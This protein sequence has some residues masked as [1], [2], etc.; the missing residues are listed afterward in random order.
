M[1]IA[2]AFLAA[3]QREN[4]SFS[5]SLNFHMLEIEYRGL[6]KRKKGLKKS[7]N[8]RVDWYFSLIESCAWGNLRVI[9]CEFGAISLRLVEY[10]AGN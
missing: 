4:N 9:E 10:L 1:S 7:S 5:S 6:Y 8:N 3:S 2:V